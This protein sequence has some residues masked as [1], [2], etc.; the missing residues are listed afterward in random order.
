M[1]VQVGYPISNAHA[2]GRPEIRISSQFINGLQRAYE[3]RVGRAAT[4]E[5]V[6]RLTQEYLEE[7]ILFREAIRAGLMKDNKVRALWVH[8]MRTSLRPIVGP[9]SD[10]DIEALRREAPASYRFPFKIAFEHVSYSSAANIPEGLLERLRGGEEPGLFGDKIALA[11]P[12]P[13]TFTGGF[14]KLPSIIPKPPI[15]SAGQWGTSMGLRVANGYGIYDMNGNAWEWVWDR[16]APYENGT[17]FDPKGPDSGDVRMTRGGSWWN[18]EARQPE[19]E[20]PKGH[21][22]KLIL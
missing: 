18:N 11:N 16:S 14:I 12:L 1:G 10:A 9:P 4:E 3:A 22:R 6:A 15:R 17:Q 21:S 13:P 8:T 19:R 5:E 20:N 7:E 2:C